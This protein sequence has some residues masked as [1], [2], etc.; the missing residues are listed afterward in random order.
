MSKKKPGPLY[1]TIPWM[2]EHAVPIG[3]LQL[4]PANERAHDRANID[5][6]KGSIRRFGIMEPLGVRH[7]SVLRGN[8]TLTAIRELALEQATAL[9]PL[10]T[11]VGDEPQTWDLVPVTVLDHLSDADAAAW[12]VTHNRTAE[13][14]KWDWSALAATLEQ[15]GNTEDWAVVGWSATE[16]ESIIE[17]HRPKDIDPEATTTVSEHERN[18]EAPEDFAEYDEE[19]IET[20]YKC[21][22][23]AYEWSGKPK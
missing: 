21:P 10:S 9:A 2:R 5:A 14:G 19:T 18:L 23:C 12:R 11:I 22:K 15:H 7:G 1:I 16:L 3:D 4:D 8:G 6:I 20:Q 13:L 17:A